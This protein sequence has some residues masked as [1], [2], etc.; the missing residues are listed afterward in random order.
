MPKNPTKWSSVLNRN[1]IVHAAESITLKLLRNPVVHKSDIN[2]WRNMELR[3]LK[4]PTLMNPLY[5]TARDF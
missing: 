1:S 4:K 2:N 5:L 3:I